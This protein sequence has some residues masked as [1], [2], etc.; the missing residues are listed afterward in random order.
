VEHSIR[1]AF[2]ANEPLQN[3]KLVMDLSQDKDGHDIFPGG[4]TIAFPITE[5]RESGGTPEI[6]SMIITFTGQAVTSVA[7]NIFSNW[8]WDKLIQKRVK[9]IE[10]DGLVIDLND[11]GKFKHIMA[12]KIKI[13]E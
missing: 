3:S 12:D 2:G 10:I 8:L 1:I 13:E 11:K 9:K 4:A 6:L 5:M 7:F